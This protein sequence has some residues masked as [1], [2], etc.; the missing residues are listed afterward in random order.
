[1]LFLTIL[2]TVQLDM[3][4]NNCNE[5]NNNGKLENSAIPH[6][7]NC[8]KLVHL[9]YRRVFTPVIML[10]LHWN[11][12]WMWYIPDS[13]PTLVISSLII[14]R[15]HGMSAAMSTTPFSKPANSETNT[16]NLVV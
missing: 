12:H 14:E 11:L 7:S 2:I 13:L 10:I 4:K 6:I 9:A 8:L 15:S 5:K 1:M 3:L 16:D